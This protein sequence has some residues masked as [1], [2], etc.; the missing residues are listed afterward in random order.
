MM[1]RNESKY[2]KDSNF[3]FRNLSVVILGEI[4]LLR[5]RPIGLNSSSNF[6]TN[7]YLKKKLESILFGIIS[8]NN[9]VNILVIL[10]QITQY[11]DF[12]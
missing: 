3:Y 5:G 7:K 12:Y 2:D 11:C 4:F 8:S 10:P 1:A 6:T 9:F